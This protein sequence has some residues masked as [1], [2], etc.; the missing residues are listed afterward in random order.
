M[1]AGNADFMFDTPGWVDAFGMLGRFW[2]WA[3]QNPLFEE[4]KNSRLPWILP[5]FILHR[6]FDVVTAS[7][8]LHATALLSSSIAVYLVLRDSLEDKPTAAVTSAA[9]S[10]FTWIHGDGGWDYHVLAASSY[11]LFSV[12]MFVRAA[13]SRMHARNWALAGGA[14]LACAVHTHVVFAVLVPVVPMLYLVEPAAQLPERTTRLARAAVHG[15]LGGLALT[16]LLAVPNAATGGDW[17]FFLPQIEAALRLGAGNRW[18]VSPA[19]WIPIESRHLVIPCLILL[20]GGIWV[21]ARRFQRTRDD[22]RPGRF[23]AVLAY[24]GFVVFGLVAFL[25]FVAHQT[26][27]HPS[28]GSPLLYGQAFLMLGA[29]LW[30]SGH[31]KRQSAAVAVIAT[32]AVVT[33]L[34]VLLPW[35]LQSWVTELGQLFDWQFVQSPLLPVAVGVVGVGVT[36]CLKAPWRLVSFALF[37]GLLN[38]WVSISPTSYGIGTP[39]SNRDALRVI[40]SLDRYTSRLDPSLFAIRFWREPEKVPGPH[41]PIDLAH[42]YESF[43]ST[44]RRSLV[45]AAFDRPTIRAEELVRDDLYT[46]RCVGVLSSSAAH[47]EVVER[48]KHRFDALGLPLMEVG[49]HD[50]SSGPISVTLTVLALP[51]DHSIVGY[52]DVPCPPRR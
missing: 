51:R 28:F 17:L 7:Y 41:G 45:V 42:L 13:I 12:W 35:R 11:Y 26:I 39:G 47:G 2:H 32:V 48:I 18:F 40:R 46:E 52:E 1:I 5:G 33:P 29:L 20:A 21:A 38:A 30:H 36:F 4:Y 6:L 49:R 16:A 9:W 8:I 22:S 44:R 27:V 37:F 19:T 50:A 34:L 14:A 25:Q 15:L 23:A 43:V 10:C 24:Q 3:D 31:G